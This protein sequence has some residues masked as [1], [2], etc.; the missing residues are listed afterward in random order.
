MFFVDKKDLKGK[1]SSK[2]RRRFIAGW[3]INKDVLNNA[4]KLKYM[5]YSGAGMR[6]SLSL[7]NRK[8]NIMVI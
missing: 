8:L 5:F 4:L 3:I 1:K 7:Q 2:K 6:K